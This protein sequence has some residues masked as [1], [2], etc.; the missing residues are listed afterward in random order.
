MDPLT[1]AA[2]AQAVGAAPPNHDEEQVLV[3]GVSIDSRT[4]VKGDLFFALGGDRVDGHGYLDQARRAG[5]AAAVVRRGEPLPPMEEPFPLLVVEDP[6][7]AL[8]RL[9]THHRARLTAIVVG[10]TGSNGKTTTK[11]MVGAV[12]SELGPTIRSWKS[13][14][15]DLGVPLTILAADASTRFLVVEIGTNHP[16]EIARLAAMARPLVGVVTNIAEAH[17]GNFGSLRAIAEE[18]AALLEALPPDGT[19]VVPAGDA[20]SDLLASRA[21]CR[22]CTFGRLDAPGTEIATDVWGTAV[23]RT[24]RPRG[25]SFHLYGKMRVQLR[26]QGVHNAV[27]AL[28][29]CAVG[30]LC[31]VPPET[32]QSALAGV[33]PPALRLQRESVGGVAL[34]DDTY[35]ANPASMDAALDEIAASA[36][37]GRRVLVLGDMAELGEASESQHR[38]LGRRAAAVG[39]ILWAVGEEARLVAEE[40]LRMG[41]PADR[42]FHSPGVD[43]ALER[44]PFLPTPGDLV[45]VK[46]SRS[47]G[48]DRLAGALRVALE[49]RQRERE[50][51]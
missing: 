7:E 22:V 2:V 3:R 46:A 1:L 14:N 17:I 27:N 20:F 33:A 39:D 18:K 28:A 30:L 49:A 9:A 35:N 45:L 47:S 4:V 19:A 13:Y 38:R 32:L 37:D 31:G 43:L 11:D 29:A 51:V 8:G 50:R 23:R 42:V 10:I 41:V 15:N 12:L 21:P 26:F 36:T 16:G 5:A 25:V 40:A 6:R 44:L 48:L 34:V 24:G